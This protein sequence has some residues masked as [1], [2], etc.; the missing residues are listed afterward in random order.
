VLGEYRS[1]LSGEKPK[2]SYSTR[3]IMRDGQERQVVVNSALIEWEGKP[4]TLAMI[5]D[6]TEQKQLEEKLMRSENHF[7][8]LVEQSPLDTVIMTP[9]GKIREVNKAWFH[10]WDVQAEEADMIMAAY[11]I[12]TDSHFAKLGIAPLVERAFA[13]ENVVLPPVHYIPNREFDETE[14]EKIEAKDRWIQSHLFS[15]KDTNGNVESVVGINVDITDLKKAEYQVIS[16]GLRFRYLM[17][18]SP[19][20]TEILSLEGKIIEVNPAWYRLWGVDEA[21][22]AEV[23]KKYNMRTDPQLENMGL[24]DL[25]ERA[26]SGE[27]IV[28]PPIRYDSIETIEDFSL[29][30]I[31]GTRVPWIQAHL[32]PITDTDGKLTNIVNTYVDISD[33]KSTENELR[34]ALKEIE[35]LKDRLEA[36][37]NYLREEIKLEHNFES[38]IGNS[39]EL[40][41]TLNRVEQ[42]APTDSPVLIMGETGTGK[43]LIARALHE[44]SPRKKRV[45]V[46]VNCAAL[47]AELI[48]SEL[49]GRE[50][51][52]FTGAATAQAGRF[53]VAH[54]S[55]LF[56]DEI[57]ELPI[58]LQAKLLRVLDSGEFER[59]GS[60]H[61]RHS[62]ARVIAA[63]NRELEEEVKENRFREDLWFRL[64]VFPITVPPLRERVED[65]PLLARFFVDYFTRKMGKKSADLTIRTMKM[66]QQYHWPGNVR[67]LKHSIEGACITL[68][69]RNL[70]IDLPQIKDQQSSDFQSFAE[71]ERDYIIRVLE[72]KNWKIGGANSAAST[73]GMHVNTLRG[74]MKKLGIKKN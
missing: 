70:Q 22:A 55:T 20:P 26:F 67:E 34:S 44:L 59:L 40:K 4:A 71:M 52:A 74:R 49:F 64:K 61:T 19:M 37:S 60:T 23:M 5:T 29:E 28:L 36:E 32:F 21:G 57:G 56:L 3:L 14:L 6:L 47:P 42:V 50:K 43:E 46:K 2:S 31:E 69:G 39:A 33:L 62:N 1:R 41:Y 53:E 66:L 7:R 18:Q 10:N 65:V 8:N 11:N 16:T 9:E 15:I 27:Q 35:E 58:E 68:Q 30:N 12:R 13:G 24:G 51:G 73:L 38:I 48:E 25:V 54:G 72:S 17:E 63:T 45:L